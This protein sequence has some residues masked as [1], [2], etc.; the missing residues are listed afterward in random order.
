VRVP[1]AAARRRQSAKPQRLAE[2]LDIDCLQHNSVQRR[3][4]LRFGGKLRTP[5]MQAG[6]TTRP[7]TL[8]E[9]FLWQRPPSKYSPPGNWSPISLPRSTP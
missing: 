1:L 8:H 6:N 7:L 9:I 5:A 3:H 4:T 2:L